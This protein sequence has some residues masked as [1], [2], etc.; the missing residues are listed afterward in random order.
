M[1]KVRVLLV[2]ICRGSWERV[3]VG[4]FL[5][6]AC[7]VAALDR[8]IDVLVQDVD[9][10]PT[11]C[12]RNA[13]VA[14]ARQIGAG[15]L[16]MVDADMLPSLTFFQHAINFLLAH[17]GAVVI[18]SPYCGAPPGRLVQVLGQGAARVSRSEAARATGTQLVYC[19]G[20]GLFA[21]NM[22]A[23]DLLPPPQ[24]DY[25]YEGPERTLAT[26]EDFAFCRRFSDAGGRVYC[27][28]G[29]WSSHAKVEIV[30]KPE[31]EPEPEPLLPGAGERPAMQ[32]RIVIDIDGGILSIGATPMNVAEINLWLDVA[33]GQ[34]LTQGGADSTIETAPQE[35][36][37]NGQ[38][39]ATA[40][41]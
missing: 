14:L 23:F 41:R 26:T 2:R 9:Q 38:Q 28:W 29:H 37:A 36:P 8:H 32:A 22:A 33:K 35:A 21:A 39:A 6:H 12:A 3:E 30:G 16:L 31:L 11:S 34:V 4:R 7:C 5:A 25:E 13:A 24:F 27:A 15:I 40:D 18:G 17:R 20:T 19:V 1:S 10:E